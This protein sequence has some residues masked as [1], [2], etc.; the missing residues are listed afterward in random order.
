M[1]VMKKVLAGVVALLFVALLGYRAAA[2][3]ND[4]QRAAQD[5]AQIEKLM[6]RY[7]RAL[8]TE[9]PD[10]YAATYTPDGQF[11]NGANAVKGREALKKMI[12]GF[13]QRTAD[14]EAK[15]E[16][17]P[18]MYHVIANNYL[19]FLDRNHARMEAYW[20][21]VFA[22]AGPNVPVR[23]AA[24]GREVDELVRVNGQWLIKLRDV[25]PKD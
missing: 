18:P 15:G 3:G 2:G 9:N 22:Q 24:A 16:K 7:V 14:A 8:D 1:R 17:R 10:A 5:R 23:V 6:W 25:A 21:T 19:E 20:M 11:G 12:A 13:R 4:T